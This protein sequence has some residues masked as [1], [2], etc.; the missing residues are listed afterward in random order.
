MKRLN[1][2]VADLEAK[3]TPPFGRTHSIIQRVGHTQD[4]AI[5]AYGRALI[6]EDDLLIINVIVA[7]NEAA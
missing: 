7:P 4:E 6:G 5:D 2:R 1:T 3:R